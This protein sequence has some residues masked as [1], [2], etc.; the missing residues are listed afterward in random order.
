MD[1]SAHHVLYLAG[2]LAL[3]L[4]LQLHLD[5]LQ[6]GSLLLLVIPRL[7]LQAG[8]LL[9]LV[10]PRLLLHLPCLLLLQQ[11]LQL[12]GLLRGLLQGCCL[13]AGLAH[14]IPAHNSR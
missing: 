3:Q 13:L 14:S 9:L 1:C 6:A 2:L 4:L 8:S 10:I 11:R 12:Q 5:L 7:L